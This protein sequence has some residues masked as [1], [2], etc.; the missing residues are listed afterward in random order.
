[1]NVYYKMLKGGDSIA[2]R[3]L[4]LESLKLHPECFGSGYEEQSQ[5]SQLYFEKLIEQ[6]STKGIMLG[7]FNGRELIGLCG[8]IPSTSTAIEIIQMYV[9]KKARGKGGCSEI[10]ELSKRA[11]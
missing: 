10:T 4:R 11:S 3:A 5:L 9:A 6:K 1:M 8:L 7:A 2:Y